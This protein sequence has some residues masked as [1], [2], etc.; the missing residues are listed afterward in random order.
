VKIRETEK[1]DD[2]NLISDVVYLYMWM[3]KRVYDL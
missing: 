2:M 1:T 3:Y